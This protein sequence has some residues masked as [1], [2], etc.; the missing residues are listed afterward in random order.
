MNKFAFLSFLLFASVPA[1][2]ETDKPL[3]AH[4]GSDLKPDP[5]QVFGS[6]ENGLRWV[7][8]PNAEP[9]KRVSIRLHIAAG[10]LNEEDDQQGLAHFM[11]HMAFNGTKHF[12]ADQM[13]EFFQ[14]LGMAFGAD[15]NA[16]TSFDETVYKLELP[17]NNAD[18][19]NKGMLFM[20]DV[21]DGMIVGPQEIE[22]ERGVILS[23][24][25]ARDSVDFRTMIEGFKFGLPESI[26]PK[27]L[28]IGTEE[29]IKKAPKQRFTDY[30]K[31]WY[32][33]NRMVV[34][35]VGDVEV[36][37]VKKAIA[38]Q[39][40]DMK[41]PAVS[42]PDPNLGTV[43]TGKGFLAKLHTEKEAG[44]ITINVEAAKPSRKLPDNLA[45][46]L[47]DVIRQ[48]ADDMLNRRFEVLSK[49]PGS[50]FLAAQS[51][52][53]DWM[54]FV[55]GSSLEISAKPEN[56]QK[57]L[58]AGEQELRRAVLHGFTKSELTEAVANFQT[59]VENAAAEA[60][61]RKSRALADAISSNISD[62]KV[63]VHPSDALTWAK[64]ALPGITAEQCHEALQKDWVTEDIRVF[65]GGNLSLEKAESAIAAAWKK[66]G[67]VEVAPQEEGAEA[68][69]AY[70]SFG[71][72]GKVTAQKVVD[73]LNITQL[74][75]ANG[76][77]LNI[78]PTDFKKDTIEMA[79]NFGQGKLTA[80]QDKP[81][82]PLFTQFNFETGALGKHSMDDLQRVLAGKTVDIT[83]S[84]GD[85][86]FGL[87]GKTNRKNLKTQFQLL[88]A[89]LSDPGWR[90]DGLARF[91][92][93]LPVVYQQV[94]HTP[95]GVM[96]AR[97]DAFTHGDDYRFVFPAQEELAARTVAEMKA[98]LEPQLQTG[99]LEIGIVG[100]L[101]VQEVIA[102]A[103]AT[104]GA[105]PARAA[106]KTNT[107]ALRAIAFPKSTPEK[108]FAFDSKIPKS[109]AL[110]FWPTTD[111]MKDIKLSR[112]LS[113]VAEILSDRVRIKVR[114]ELGESYSPDVASMMSDTWPGYGQLM[115]MM[116]AE[117]KDAKELTGIA[118][119]LGAELAA[120]GASADELERARKPLLTALEE[121]RRNN[122]YWLGT[123]VTP[124]QSKPERLD[125]ARTMLADFTTVSL[126]DI[127]RLAKQYLGA[128]VATAVRVV[129]TGKAA[130]GEKKGK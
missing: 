130:E 2:A 107:D 30:Y 54:R 90:E 97:A 12:A 123:V 62:R 103:T 64:A 116:T 45:I 128:D 20:R 9:P 120:K 33:P 92:M 36:E 88:A 18:F 6:M 42:A 65:I 106:E 52:H 39:F 109:T 51:S 125:W 105:L 118:R 124:S 104:V 110:V 102:A 74:Q 96:R 8:L 28:P 89:F 55:E 24:K 93:S 75:F 38:E 10:S 23:E 68:A 73:D 83:F 43:T 4:E 26:I 47:K 1:A 126:E 112:Q 66:S 16:H 14:R 76:V 21:A 101:D 67:G 19:V 37:A 59:A 35:V 71:E 3:W 31:K 72:P 113:L 63:F 15:T 60:P 122:A 95:E 58:A 121:Q 86:S 13:V 48:L 7:I 114:E 44:K 22:K 100:D 127:N 99:Y 77:R 82:L 129:S 56:W 85:D 91:K 25:N 27:R 40:A 46:R 115:A 69:W 79:A 81:G 111:R 34:I 32:T 84:V 70:A 80:P 49:K 29:V 53:Q 117:A 94:N 87:S 78:K 41:A 61:T 119:K 108:E 50:P 11:E 98:W 5:K 17:D 57:A